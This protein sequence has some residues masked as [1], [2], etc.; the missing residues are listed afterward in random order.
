M[1]SCARAIAFTA[2]MDFG[3]FCSDQRTRSAVQ[4]EVFVLGEAAK[5]LPEAIRAR[6]GEVNW[7]GMVGLRDVL[8][9]HYFRIDDAILWDVVRNELPW[10]V[11]EVAGHR[12][13]G[14]GMTRERQARTNPRA[15]STGGTTPPRG[16]PR[17]CAWLPAPPRA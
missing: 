4:R 1:E 5:H 7:R 15:Q 11:G 10:P 6:H 8:A 12:R 3:T 14:T 9:H 16:A 13:K 17:R 2:N